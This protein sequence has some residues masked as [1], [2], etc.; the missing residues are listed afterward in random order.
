MKDN[1]VFAILKKTSLMKL[2]NSKVELAAIDDLDSAIDKSEIYSRV[3]LINEAIADSDEIIDLYEELKFKTESYYNKYED[4]NNWY[5]Q[6]KVERNNLEEKLN[7]YETLTDELGID[8]NNSESYRYGDD[9]ITDMDD[10]YLTYDQ[11]YDRFIYA[12]KISNNLNI[13]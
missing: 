7:T 10:E 6:A 4:I 3:I 13:N 12:E 2:K 9:L 8:A 5:S 1:K 11:N